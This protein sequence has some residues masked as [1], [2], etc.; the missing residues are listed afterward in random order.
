METQNQ[1][2]VDGFFFWQEGCIDDALWIEFLQHCMYKDCSFESL[3]PELVVPKEQARSTL[4]ARS[5]DDSSRA[6]VYS[7]KI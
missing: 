1:G 3:C 5:T 4:P 2:R 6:Q 7:N